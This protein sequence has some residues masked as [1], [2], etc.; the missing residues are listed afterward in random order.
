MEV[1]DRVYLIK[2]GTIIV[3]DTTQP[4]LEIL[5]EPGKLS[6]AT[7]LQ[8]NW[9]LLNFTSGELLIQ[10]EFENP[11]YVSSNI[12]PDQLSI[13]VHGFYMFADKKGN[14]MMP[15]FVLNRKIVPR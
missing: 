7:M 1:P 5:I 4:F 15:E 2:N 11:E 14:Y 9:K 6:N 13:I 8:F 12:Y 3:N 10:L